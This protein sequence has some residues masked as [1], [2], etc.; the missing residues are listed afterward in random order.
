[1]MNASSHTRPPLELWGGVECS[2]TRIGDR[3]CDQMECTGH[4]QRPGDLDLFSKLGIRAF[5]L[6]VLWER[7]APDGL[8]RANW[9][10]SDDRLQRM[11][12]L[13]IRPIV[14]L[15]H[16]GSGPPST[17]LL[18]SS[19]AEGLAQFAGAAARR[20]PWVD[21][22]TP[23]NEPLTTARFSALY[24]HWYPHD[25]D[26]L[27]FAHALLNQCRAVVMAMAAVR[28][29]NPTA[30]LVQ[31]EDL[32]KTFSTP[33]LAYQAHFE[34]ERRWI[35]WDLLCGRVDHQ[36]PM[37][38]FLRWVGVEEHQLTWFLDHPC[39]PD[40][41]GINHYVTSE[42]FLDERAEHYPSGTHG[43]NGRHAYADVE[44]VRVRATGPTGPAILL[45]EAW[46]RYQ[47]PMAVTEVHL[48]C[49]RE[50]QLRWLVEV[51]NAVRSRRAA[52]ADIR[53]VTAWSLLGAFD[54]DS[55][56]TCRAGRYEPGVFDLRSAWPRP[57][58]LASAL[59]DLAAGRHPDHPAL[60]TP[61]WWRR[62]ERL[63]YPSARAGAPSADAG[64]RHRSRPQRRGRPLLI[65][66]AAGTL[67]RAFARICA[68]RG[69]VHRL[70][71]R[72]DLDIA[73]PVS[74][75]AA[76]AAYRPWAVINAAGF[77]RVDAA[78]H[79]SEACHRANAE[80]PAVLAAACAARH[81]GLLTFSSDL[82][83]DG[84]R[85]RPYRESDPTAPLCV[86]G[87]SKAAAER[88]V[89]RTHPAALVIRTSAF[90]GPWDR[91][92]FVAVALG[93]LAAGRPF[94]AANDVIVSPTYVPDLVHASL[95]LLIDREH[96]LWH[97]ANTGALSWLDFARSAAAVAGLDGA[98]V[99]GSP[100]HALGFT[101][102]R[103]RYSALGS[104]RALLLP[105]LEDAIR[106][107]CREC[108]VRW[109]DERSVAYV[110]A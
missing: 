94:V 42:R 105:P 97:L 84:R 21:A 67:G 63:L 51:W 11:Q 4:A 18:E 98:R 36:H 33:L 49:T 108:E 80:G 76:L 109:Q 62:P 44:A 55:L 54:W 32:G 29:V 82:V 41:L 66:G 86:Y 56:M 22:Y 45:Q 2:V 73:D 95:D 17:N 13:G 85:E 92:N 53:A 20:Y 106:R 110:S 3:H 10:W 30:Q 68:Q 75:A 93:T 87:R 89:L 43:G 40:I 31:T 104:E 14:G 57:T 35:T 52:G 99:E 83:F 5:R 102:P 59:R 9:S 25:R 77:V 61:G 15:V 79:E 70:L 65:V 19:F 24:G 34:N 74:V 1:M 101:A 38:G 23:I 81:V 27:R 16:H 37:W 69:L 100:T 88:R 48:G 107:Y 72:R 64:T 58:A 26:A 47:R 50:E 96:G 8:H 91:Q 60:A 46:Q 78:E 39:P 7:V 6:G 90:F 103:P 71:P 28:Q 12:A